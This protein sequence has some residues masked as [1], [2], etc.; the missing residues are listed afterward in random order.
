[1]NVA[2]YIP[3]PQ[4][5]FRFPAASCREPAIRIRPQ[6]RNPVSGNYIIQ[7]IITAS[8]QCRKE[9]VP[10][11]VHSRPRAVFADSARPEIPSLKGTSV[12]QLRI[13]YTNLYNRAVFYIIFVIGN[14]GFGSRPTLHPRPAQNAGSGVRPA[15]V[16]KE[17]Q[18]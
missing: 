1:M 13:W 10:T 4:D 12:A 11:V 6:S 9:T 2:A 15:P 14:N 17:Q 8:L 5:R 18:T 3:S 7:C 16:R